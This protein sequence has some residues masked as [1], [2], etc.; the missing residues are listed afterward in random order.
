[1]GKSGVTVKPKLYIAAG[2]SGAPEHVEG[3][4]DSDLIIAINSDAQAPIFNVA[5]IGIVGDVADMLP[6]LAEAVRSRKG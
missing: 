1:V 5:D 2:I 4:R 3:M 6:A